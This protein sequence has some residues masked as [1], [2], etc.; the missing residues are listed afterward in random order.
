MKKTLLLFFLFFNLLNM[1]AQDT[2]FKEISIRDLQ[3]NV[4]KLIGDDWMLITAGTIDSCNMMTASWGGVGVLWNRPV[5]FAFIRPERYTREFIDAKNEFTITFLGPEHRKAHSI[6]GSKSG[7]EIDKVAATG[8]TPLF[9]E[10]GN[11]VFEEARLTLE[12]KV[13]YKSEIEEA[14]FLDPSVFPRWYDEKNGNAHIVYI[15]EIVNAW[16]K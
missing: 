14:K 8:L 1:N 3:D 13:V 15:A 5:V 10:A 4:V 12:C 7:R 9:T 16:E 11:P 2:L 6:C